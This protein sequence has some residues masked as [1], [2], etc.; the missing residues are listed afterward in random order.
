MLIEAPAICVGIH[1]IE[2][3]SFSDCFFFVAKRQDALVDTIDVFLVFRQ[4][5]TVEF[6]TIPPATNS[7]HAPIIKNSGTPVSATE[8]F[9]IHAQFTEFLPEINHH[10]IGIHTC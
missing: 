3:F 10:R 2:E 9:A 8:T 4:H 5:L 6:S 1:K 7:I